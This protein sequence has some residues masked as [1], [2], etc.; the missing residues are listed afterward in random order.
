[1]LDVMEFVDTLPDTPEALLGV[2][3]TSYTT[4]NPRTTYW[5]GDGEKPTRP[6]RGDRE[7]DADADSDSAS[8][9]YYAKLFARNV[10]LSF[11]RPS[12]QHISFQRIN[13]ERPSFQH[14]GF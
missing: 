13:F 10:L 8:Y 9:P 2:V 1:M 12:F 6:D 11:K 14:I 7:D 3:L 4:W 5:D